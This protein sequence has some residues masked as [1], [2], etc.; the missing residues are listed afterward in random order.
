V[1]AGELIAS[2]VSANRHGLGRRAAPGGLSGGLAP[3]RRHGDEVSIGDH[4]PRAGV[5]LGHVAE[6]DDRVHAMGRHHPRDLDQWCL[7]RASKHAAVH[8]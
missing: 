7:E 6:A 8:R 5:V 4:P 2:P 1:I 3:R